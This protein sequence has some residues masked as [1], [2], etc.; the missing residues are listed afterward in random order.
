MWSSFEVLLQQSPAV[1]LDTS[2]PFEAAAARF[3]HAAFRKLE[4]ETVACRI[5]LR[6]RIDLNKR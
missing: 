5:A 6:Q 4:L 1:G 2:L 3:M